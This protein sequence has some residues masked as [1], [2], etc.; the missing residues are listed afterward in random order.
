MEEYI[1]CG[2]VVEAYAL[3]LAR[4]ERLGPCTRLTFACPRGRENLAVLKVIVPTDALPVIAQQL[5][6]PYDGVQATAMH[7]PPALLS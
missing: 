3:T 1:D 5:A 6:A 7:R 2:Y 4:I